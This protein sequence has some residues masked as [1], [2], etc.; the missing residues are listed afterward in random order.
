MKKE[1]LDKVLYELKV[2]LRDEAYKELMRRGQ[3]IL[4]DEKE[5]RNSMKYNLG[6]NPII[7]TVF[8]I[9]STVLVG[10]LFVGW[11]MG[12][13]RIQS[14]EGMI[15]IQ[16]VEST[17]SSTQV[18]TINIKNVSSI[19]VSL[20]SLEVEINDLPNKTEVTYEVMPT[21]TSYLRDGDD[22]DNYEWI[23]ISLDSIPLESQHRETT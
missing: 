7:A 21:S 3:A 18:L 9:I 1:D 16:T 2:F 6:L 20:I 22:D 4:L 17:S 10:A 13:I 11:Q 8:L 12:W 23:S 15:S 14:Q 19:R 5:G